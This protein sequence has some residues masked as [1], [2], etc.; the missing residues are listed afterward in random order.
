M[1]KQHSSFKLL[2]TFLIIT[3]SRRNNFSAY[4]EEGL[5]ACH[6]SKNVQQAEDLHRLARSRI[7]LVFRKKRDAVEVNQDQVTEDDFKVLR[8]VNIDIFRKL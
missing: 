2:V 7:K 5:Y 4:V 8:S 3:I 1:D 6:K